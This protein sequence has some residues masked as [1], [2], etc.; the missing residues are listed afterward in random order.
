MRIQPALAVTALLTL[1]VG[2]VVAPVELHRS[3]STRSAPP[4]AIERTA[5]DAKE[6]LAARQSGSAAPTSAQQIAGPPTPA[7]V[8]PTP[9]SPTGATPVDVPSARPTVAT[10]VVDPSVL[11]PV[12]A[13]LPA[14]TR[15]DIT[16]LLAKLT[17]GDL[18]LVGGVTRSVDV[19]YLPAIGRVL[20]DPAAVLLEL[21][22]L[23]VSVPT[24]TVPTI[25]ELLGAVPFGGE[26]TLSG[27]IPTLLGANGPALAAALATLPAAERAPLSTLLTTLSPAGFRT[28]ASLIGRIPSG[29]SAVVGTA[30]DHLSPAGVAAFAGL[31]AGIAASDVPPITQVLGLL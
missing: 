11:G 2:A 9:T 22:A 7:P 3:S 21:Q 19:A 18:A 4:S 14:S 25:G 20:D 16:A 27:M 23:L 13:A 30:L 1:G 31:L 28:L 5:L 12:T 8:T 6:V 24:Y 10:Q 17:P 15:T 26:A 29:R